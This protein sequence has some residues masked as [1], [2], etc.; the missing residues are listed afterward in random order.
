LALIELPRQ[1]WISQ[2][3]VVKESE[4]TNR[5]YQADFYEICGKMR[6]RENR[7]WKAAKIKYAITSLSRYSVE[8]LSRSLCVD[9]GCSSGVMTNQLAPLFEQT[10]GL[11]YDRIALHHLDKM[12]TPAAA[13]ARGDAMNL[14]LG[15]ETADVIICSQV[16]EHVPDDRQL[17][18]EL[19]R[20]LKPGGM[21]FLSGP[22]R[23]FPWEFHYSL[24]FFHWLPRPLA[25]LVLRML[26]RGD[27][28]YEN[29]RTI[30]S[31]RAALRSFEIQDVTVD[32]LTQNPRTVV[33]HKWIPWVR[34][35]PAVLWQALLPLFPN[36]NWLLYK[37]LSHR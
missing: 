13:F 5:G 25:N 34:R 12:E 28:F 9:V 31:L 4:L 16:Y 3:E 6:D 14:P 37:P 29:L 24:P 7:L 32:L 19:Y 1:L 18:A 8:T 20:I 17:F 10:L 35:V 15:D 11:E 33:S 23:L 26:G 2:Y 21:I 22:N 36:F 27:Y 30:W